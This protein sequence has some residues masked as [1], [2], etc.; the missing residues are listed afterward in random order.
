M[1]AQV[2]QVF[3][4]VGTP[5]GKAFSVWTIQRYKQGERTH[6]RVRV[7]VCVS[8]KPQREGEPEMTESVCA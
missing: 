5:A 1:C 3:D 7:R 6:Q 4:A 2:N 8:D